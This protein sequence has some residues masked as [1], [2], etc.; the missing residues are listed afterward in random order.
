MAYVPSIPGFS[1]VSFGQ[2]YGD[3]QQYAGHGKD[4]PFGASPSMLPKKATKTPIAP[5]QLPSPALQ[6]MKPIDYS[7][8]PTGQMGDFTEKLCELTLKS[9]DKDFSC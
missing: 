2:G 9:L 6:E 3:W 5:P 8:A 4:N 1:P 7:L